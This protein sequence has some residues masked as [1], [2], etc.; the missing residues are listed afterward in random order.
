MGVPGL[1]PVRLPIA[2]S[3]F[4]ILINKGVFMRGQAQRLIMQLMKRTSQACNVAVVSARTEGALMGLLAKQRTLL[5]TQDREDCGPD[6]R[7][8]RAEKGF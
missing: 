2:E 1:T 3:C 8:A 7:C 6:T 5:K 4:V